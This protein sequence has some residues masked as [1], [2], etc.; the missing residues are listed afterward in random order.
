M[1][2]LFE[3]RFKIYK[4]GNSAG[5]SLDSKAGSETGTINRGHLYLSTTCISDLWVQKMTLFL[6]YVFCNFIV[7]G[8]T[9]F[10][11][12]SIYSA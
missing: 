7:S 10:A 8:Q 4:M 2:I 1:K 9:L 11:M 12:D 5:S 3:R 6:S